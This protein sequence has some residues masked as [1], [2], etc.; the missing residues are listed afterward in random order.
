MALEGVAVV[1]VSPR[2]PENIGM[3]ARACANMGVSELVVVSPERWSPDKSAPLATA[4]GLVVLEGVRLEQTLHE[5]LAPY[6]AVFGTTARTGGWR[7]H[8][9]SPENAAPLVRAEVGRGGRVA[10]VFGPEDRGLTNEE[11]EICSRLVSIPTSEARSLNVAQAVLIMLY[12]CFK[13]AQATPH[14]RRDG[15]EQESSPV[16]AHREQEL[17][18][19]TLQET[20]LAIGYLHKSGTDY[21]MLPVRRFV[22]KIPLRRYEFDMLMGICRQM[23][24]MVRQAAKHTSRDS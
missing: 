17:L 21:F 1:L 5:A 22:Q 16:L 19:R 2:F 15:Q 4:K 13:V 3:A 14:F 7:R 20:L 8:I 11:T 9:L 24:H 18:F 12:E 10:L 23:R 6:S